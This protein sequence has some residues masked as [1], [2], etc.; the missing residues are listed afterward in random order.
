MYR[1]VVDVPALVVVG[2]A[3]HGVEVEPY[4]ELLQPVHVEHGLEVVGVEHVPRAV[5]EVVDVRLEAESVVHARVV[6]LDVSDVVAVAVQAF[7]VLGLE[8]RGEVHV[9]GTRAGDVDRRGPGDTVVGA[10][11]PVVIER[12]APVV[13]EAVRGGVRPVRLGVPQVPAQ[14]VPIVERTLEVLVKEDRC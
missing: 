14:V 12:V 3:I 6:D 13:G 9:D 8:P 11:R 10:E 5:R 7:A 4:A 1:D 2:N